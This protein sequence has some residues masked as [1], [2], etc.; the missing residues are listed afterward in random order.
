[1]E[2]TI[3]ASKIKSNLVVKTDDPVVNAYLAATE[4]RAAWLGL[5]YDE[6]QKD[7][8]GELVKK[9]LWNATYRYGQMAGNTLKK[10]LPDGP[11]DCD[12]F[13]AVFREGGFRGAALQTKVVSQ[14]SEQ[15]SLEYHGCP[16]LDTWKKLGLD[17]ETCRML[18]GITMNQDTG[19]A[20]TLGLKFDLHETLA[21]GGE[22][23]KCAYHK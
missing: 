17:D 22:C 23:C 18:C 16:L 5:I 9:Y 12:K 2:V 4:Q 13:A 10:K 1:M 21:D 7:G 3:M 20:E 19:I 15:L 11:V 6:A 8:Q 14:S